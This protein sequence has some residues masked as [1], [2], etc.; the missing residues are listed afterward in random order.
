M[1]YIGNWPTTVG[2]RAVN[3]KAIADTKQTISQSG[4]RVRVSVAGTRFQATLQYPNVSITQFRAIQAVA[5]RAEG[6]LNSFDIILPNVSDNQSGTSGTTALVSGTNAAGSSSVNITTN[7][8]STTILSA[9]DVIRFPGHNKVYMATA[10]VTTDGS[11]AATVNITPN[12]M[13]AEVGD[14]S[15]AVTLDDV[16]FRMTLNGDIQQF[17]YAVND[18]VTYEIDVLEEV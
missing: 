6:A 14:G 3:F 12:L 5:T 4:R 13:E 16:P 10:N 15:S 9:G 1:A 17:K 18:T 2:F 11:G 7:K 8:N